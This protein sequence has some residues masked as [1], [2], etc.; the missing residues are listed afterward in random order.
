M[1]KVIFIF[2]LFTSFLLGGCTEENNQVD[3]IRAKVVNIVDGDTIDVMINEKKE[4]VRLILI[5]TP[6]TK[7]PRHGVQ[8]FGQEASDFTTEYLTNKEVILEKDIS[9]RDRYGRVLA[10][11][12]VGNQ[13]FNKML[14]EKGL[15]RVAIFPPDIKYVNEFEKVQ[16]TARQKGIGI[17]SIEDYVQDK[18][19]QANE[20]IKEASE[21]NRKN[22]TIKGN[23]NSK[24]EKIYHLPT[25]QYYEAVIPEAWFCSEDEA[26]NAG[27]RASKR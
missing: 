8:P 3:G 5:D 7:H 4:R 20:N 6:E 16:N 17:W 19:Y 24:R 12:W 9:E 23:I 18:G 1:K 10:Y 14:V 13:N 15:A 25:G 26:K 27:F 21:S 11:V 22:C 2:L